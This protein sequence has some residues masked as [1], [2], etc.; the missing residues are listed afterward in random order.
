MPMI[1][2]VRFQSPCIVAAEVPLPNKL[3]QCVVPTCG[4]DGA[5]HSAVEVRLAYEPRRMS[6][7][8]SAD[9]DACEPLISHGEHDWLRNVLAPAHPGHP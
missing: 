9:F 4:L 5:P 1:S 3:H 2:G 8:N 7:R 6:L